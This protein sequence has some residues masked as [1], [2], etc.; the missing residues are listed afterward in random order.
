MDICE[1]APSSVS[2][3]EGGTS[4]S[5]ERPILYAL[6]GLCVHRSESDMFQ[7]PR[8]FS[9]N[10]PAAQEAQSIRSAVPEL[11]PRLGLE[12]DWMFIWRRRHWIIVGVA[13]ALCLN[14]VAELTLTPRYRAATQILIGPVDLRG[15]D[16]SVMPPAQTADAN[17]IEVESETRV[18]T[19]DKVLRRVVD[20]E[21]LIADPEFNSSTP[22]K[23][24]RILSLL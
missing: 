19:S 24:G 11:F 7:N 3:P 10:A 1:R 14:L 2:A 9:P 6:P 22:S 4:C 16:K 17:V 21:R 23:I 13:A 20:T 18:L 15:V 12:N 8:G 5:D